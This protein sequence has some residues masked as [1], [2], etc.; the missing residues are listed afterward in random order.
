MCRTS[1]SYWTCTRDARKTKGSLPHPVDLSCSVKP[2]A[3]INAT[4]Q[5]FSVSTF[6]CLNTTR[7]NQVI[8]QLQILNLP[9]QWGPSNP[10]IETQTAPAPIFTTFSDLNHSFSSKFHAVSVEHLAPRIIKSIRL[11]ILLFRIFPLA[12]FY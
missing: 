8:T 11:Q 2:Q 7:K 4:S 3:E 6:R 9:N 10:F 1:N 12:P 5:S